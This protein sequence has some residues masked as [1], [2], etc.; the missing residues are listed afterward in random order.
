MICKQH[1]NHAFKDNLVLRFGL[2][3]TFPVSEQKKPLSQVRP[4]FEKLPEKWRILYFYSKLLKKLYFWGGGI[5]TL[6]GFFNLNYSKKC[7]VNLRK[8][9]KANIQNKQTKNLMK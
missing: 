7:I 9:T 8:T 6:K 5:E 1:K 2:A 4:P 3:R